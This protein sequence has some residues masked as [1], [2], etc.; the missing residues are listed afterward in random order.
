MEH[1]HAAA[2]VPLDAGWNDVGAW[3]S[4]WEVSE[5]DGSGNVIIGDQ[6]EYVKVKAT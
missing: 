3:S 6:A 5:Q 4:L 1:T 2:L